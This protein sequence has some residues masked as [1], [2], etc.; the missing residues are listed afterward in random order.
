VPVEA[1]GFALAKPESGLAMNLPTNC[2]LR[3]ARQDW[4]CR[5]QR[6][7]EKGVVWATRLPLEHVPVIGKGEQYVEDLNEAPVYGSG[8]RYCLA[9]AKM[10]CGVQD[11]P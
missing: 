1:S 10:F 5:S 8:D 4:P 7:H 2:L 11:S 3:V 6:A 9:C